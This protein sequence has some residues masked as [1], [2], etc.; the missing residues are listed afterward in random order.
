MHRCSS[1][2]YCQKQKDGSYY[3]NDLDCK[4]DPYDA[5]ICSEEDYNS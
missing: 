4:V 5:P 2:G 3:C 1:C